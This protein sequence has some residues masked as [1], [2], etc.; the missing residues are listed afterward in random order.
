MLKT[1]NGKDIA[2]IAHTLSVLLTVFGVIGVNQS[3]GAEAALST[4][5]T[6]G[7]G[8]IAQAVVVWKYIHHAEEKASPH[9]SQ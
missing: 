6:A 5:I 1:L 9:E 8:L 2:A 7:C 4:G 3:Q